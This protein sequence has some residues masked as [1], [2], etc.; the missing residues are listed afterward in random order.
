M[1][2]KDNNNIISTIGHSKVMPYE[3]R[4]RIITNFYD[5]TPPINSVDKD[6]IVGSIYIITNHKNGKQ[7]IGQTKD[8]D[9]RVRDYTRYSN[10]DKTWSNHTRLTSMYRILRDEGIENFT[11]RR[12]YDCETYE[13]M[14]EKEHSLILEYNTVV[15]N[16]YN[17]NLNTEYK[18]CNPGQKFVRIRKEEKDR[19]DNTRK[20]ANPVFIVDTKTKTIT[21]SDAGT[22]F[23]DVVDSNIERANIHSNIYRHTII[24]KRYYIYPADNLSFNV[25]TILA[26]SE[27]NRSEYCFYANEISK[28]IDYLLDNGYNIKILRYED[29]PKGF[30]YYNINEYLKLFTNNPLA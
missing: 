24:C 11:I 27:P 20:K 21:M 3:D 5:S 10:P 14:A 23:S 9:R 4:V 17:L 13:E 16:G 29:N 6:K 26:Q 28:G 22:L 19:A 2:L 1:K 30:S 25:E 15:P 8:F 18:H 7:Y 12:Y